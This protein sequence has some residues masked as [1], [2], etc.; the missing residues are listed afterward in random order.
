MAE[1]GGLENRCA[2]NPGT[3]GSNP[4]PSATAAN[5]HDLLG[6]WPWIDSEPAAAQAPTNVSGRPF[7]RRFIPPPFPPVGPEVNRANVVEARPAAASTLS[8]ATGAAERLRRIEPHAPRFSVA[9]RHP[10]NCA[11]SPAIPWLYVD[12]RSRVE[13]RNLHSFLA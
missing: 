2:G 4:S 8:S 3:E 7:W 10:S 12:N 13:V 9:D 6:V 1:S 5:S 11:E